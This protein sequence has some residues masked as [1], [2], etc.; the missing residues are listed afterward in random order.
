VV[1]VK[2]LKAQAGLQATSVSQYLLHIS[3]STVT[4]Q[5]FS[6]PP[7]LSTPSSSGHRR[8]HSSYNTD[9]SAISPLLPLLPLS[10]LL[11]LPLCLPTPTSLT[12]LLSC[13]LPLSRP[14]L[15]SC[16]SP[17]QVQSVGHPCSVYSFSALT[18]LDVPGCSLPH[19]YNKRPS[20]LTLP[21]S[22][23]A[24][25]LYRSVIGY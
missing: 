13:A 19:I 16:F 3:E 24:I 20:P 23:H 4:S 25:S 15:C 21:W 17:G 8:P 7:F 14:Q 9:T 5:L 1:S 22:G 11:C 10:S 2:H 6:P 12:L 18:F